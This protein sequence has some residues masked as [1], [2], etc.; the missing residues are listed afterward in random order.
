MSDIQVVTA[1]D[2]DTLAAFDAVIVA[3]NVARHLDT[4]LAD[5]PG[6]FKP[7][8]YCWRG[9]QRSGAM[10]TILSQVGWR[11]AVLAGGYKTYRRDVKT[12]LY[13]DEPAL[14][15]LLL[16]G[17]TGSAKTEIL[18]RLAAR[19]M[20]VLDLE[21]LCRAPR[22][23]LWRPLRPPATQPEDVQVKAADRA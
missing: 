15:L 11:T 3:R 17:R 23:G 6:D 16:D 20:Q 8:V 7:L 13:D 14:K 5:K 19:G 22:L 21:A 9:G 18:T 10:A 1:A 4:A 2:A 12:R